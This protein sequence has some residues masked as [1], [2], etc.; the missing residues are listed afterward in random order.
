MSLSTIRSAI[1]AT[2]AAVPDIGVVHAYERYAADYST[3]LALYRSPTHGQIRGW[4]VSRASTTERG[5]IFQSSAEV[6][7]WRIRGLL[8]VND[9]AATGLLIDEL[10]ESIRDAFRAD[11]T[12]GGAVAECAEPVQDGESGIQVE[13]VEFALFGSVLCHSCRLALPTYTHRLPV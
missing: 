5:Q 1:V 3:L 8:G 2:L 10:I 9:A 6:T 4:H 13:G 12:L 7:R 11:P